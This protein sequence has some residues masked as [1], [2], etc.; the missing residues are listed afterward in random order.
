[1]F[2][3]STERGILCV[4]LHVARGR[5]GAS[6]CERRD[7]VKYFSYLK[8]TMDD[9]FFFLQKLFCLLFR[10]LFCFSVHQLALGG[11]EAIK[12]E[13]ARSNRLFFLLISC[14]VILF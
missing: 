13:R 3:G 14:L 10:L 7:R 4:S 6:A 8:P 1:M 11:G 9:F 5:A 12:K 2:N